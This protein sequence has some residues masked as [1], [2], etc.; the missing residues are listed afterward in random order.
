MKE[1]RF[2]SPTDFSEKKLS[3]VFLGSDE[4]FHLQKLVYNDYP[5]DREKVVIVWRWPLFRGSNCQINS[6]NLKKSLKQRI[7]LKQM[8][9]FD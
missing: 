8:L 1:D 7:G 3:E 6:F 9:N 4:V 2:V 5:W